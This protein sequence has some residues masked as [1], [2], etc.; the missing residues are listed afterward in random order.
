MRI[1]VI[2][3]SQKTADYLCAGLKENF[4]IAE[5]ARDGQEGLF[6]ALQQNYDVIVLDVMM[7]HVDGWTFIKKFREVNQ[8]TPVIF[9][10]ARDQVEDRVKG[11]E[12]GADDYLVKP[13]A[14]SELLVRIRS[15]LRRTQAQTSELLQIADLTINTHRHIAMR[16]NRRLHLSAK[17]FMLLLLLAKRSGEVLSRTYIAEQVWDIHFDSDTNAIDVAIKRL[18]DKVDAD[19]ETKLIHTVRGAGYVLEKR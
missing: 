16:T 6:L 5:S 15:L 7:P 18:R 10:T 3:D 17:E 9:L 19:A 14:F 8:K 1:L 11:I 4:F 13:F 12:L 2:D